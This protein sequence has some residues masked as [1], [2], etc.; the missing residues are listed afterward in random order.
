MTVIKYSNYKA[1]TSYISV[2][3]SSQVYFE[4]WILWPVPE[5]IQASCRPLH[6]LLYLS[7]RGGTG[8][9][10]QLAGAAVPSTEGV[11][12]LYPDPWSDVSVLHSAG[13]SRYSALIFPSR[14]FRLYKS[15]PSFIFALIYIYKST[16]IWSTWEKLPLNCQRL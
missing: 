14:C 3:L 4:Y 2:G 16:W 9:H 13:P 12:H 15:T 1:K 7:S 10:F 5:H 6:Q 11:C 8:L